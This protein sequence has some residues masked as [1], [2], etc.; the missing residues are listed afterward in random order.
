MMVTAAACDPRLRGLVVEAIVLDIDDE[1]TR[2][3]GS[4]GPISYIPARLGKRVGGWDP[5]AARPM[6]IAANLQGRRLL[7]IDG[8]ADPI[9][10]AADRGGSSMRRRR[11]SQS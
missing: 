5:T 10:P 11:L 4:S 8:N 3:Y 9:V 2:E 7:I 1:V 6:D